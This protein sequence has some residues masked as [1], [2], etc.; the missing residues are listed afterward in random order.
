MSAMS[1]LKRRLSYK[2]KPAGKERDDPAAHSIR[3]PTDAA[4][5]ARNFE[6]VPEFIKQRER[7]AERLN[8]KEVNR[9]IRQA[10]CE[11]AVAA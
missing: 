11:D 6:G 5:K 10:Y 3:L 8:R 2:V 1:S 9:R 7:K 4:I